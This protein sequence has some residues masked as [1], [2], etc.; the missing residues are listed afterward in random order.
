[1]NDYISLLEQV[2]SV[3]EVCDE[4]EST[5]EGDEPKSLGNAAATVEEAIHAVD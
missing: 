4:L 1:M 5:N 3:D 2:E